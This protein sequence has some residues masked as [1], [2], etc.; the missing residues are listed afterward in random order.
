MILLGETL[1]SLVFFN[2]EHKH[3]SGNACQKMFILGKLSKN[4][5]ADVDLKAPIR[6]QLDPSK[7]LISCLKQPNLMIHY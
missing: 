3:I 7:C 1:Y 5:K 2:C 4:K 6:R